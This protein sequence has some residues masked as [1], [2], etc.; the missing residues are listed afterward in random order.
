M[1]R[2]IQLGVLILGMLL[3]GVERFT[4]H[5]AANTPDD[6]QQSRFGGGWPL[7]PPSRN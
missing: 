1:S 5:A 6:T 4:A 2:K 7:P 3:V